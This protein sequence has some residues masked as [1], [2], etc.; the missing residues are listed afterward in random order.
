MRSTPIRRRLKTT[1]TAVPPEYDQL[2]AMRLDRDWS[3]AYLEQQMNLAGCRISARTL[4]YMRT[5]DGRLLK[6]TWEPY[7]RTLYKIR[8]FLRLQRSHKRKADRTSAA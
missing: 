2:I 1:R 7:D 4:T 5:R 6:P 8:K 3:W